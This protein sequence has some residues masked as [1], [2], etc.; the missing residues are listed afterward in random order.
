MECGLRRQARG[1]W[2]WPIVFAALAHDA[3]GAPPESHPEMLEDAE[4]VDVF[5]FDTVRGCAVGD[6]GAILTTNDGGR[7]WHLADSPVNCRLESVFFLDE[8]NGWAVGGWTHPYT[9]KSTGVLLRTESGGRSWKRWDVPTLPALNHIFFVSTRRGWALGRPSFMYPSGVFLTEDGGRSWAPA[10]GPVWHSWEGGRFSENGQAMLVSA[11]GDVAAIGGPPRLAES[12]IP[13]G[14]RRVQALHELADSSFWVVGDGG[15]VARH[16]SDRPEVEL[17]LPAELHQFDFQAVA[18]VGSRVWV[19][20]AP[21]TR[22]FRSVDH[23]ASWEGYATGQSLPIRAL[24][25]SDAQHGWAVGS[26]GMI[27]VTRD[28]GRS[29]QLQR[30]HTRAALLGVFGEPESIP[31]EMFA[32]LA[33]DEGYLSVAE[34]LAR[35]DIES[36][37]PAESTVQDRLHEA[38]VAVGASRGSLAWQF[39][40]RQA[41]L[42]LVR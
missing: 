16:T 34:V 38:L 20:G 41:G 1:T 23:G 2:W 9:H 8:R 6:R 42:G 17:G 12:V 3:C 10:A 39:P 36:T 24:H 18:G 31:L 35:R 7:H 33:G 30:G 15:L 37:R 14:L 19:A 13:A 32:R 21:G 11:Q 5:F 40:V 29:W 28:G 27:L 4:L 22:V 26:L 25:F